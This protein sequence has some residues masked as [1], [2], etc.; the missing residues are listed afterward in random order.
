MAEIDDAPTFAE[1]PSEE[2]QGYEGLVRVRAVRPHTEIIERPAGKTFDPDE[3]PPPKPNFE[4]DF[5]VLSAPCP[6]EPE[7]KT[8]PN[9]HNTFV[10]LSPRGPQAKAAPSIG[11]MPVPGGRK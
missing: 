3:E 1:D 4:R 5:I 7:K 2:P 10:V 11:S 6:E 8:L 9:M